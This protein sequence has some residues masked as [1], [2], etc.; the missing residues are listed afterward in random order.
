M[1][2]EKC[3]STPSYTLR[4]NVRHNALNKNPHCTKIMSPGSDPVKIMFQNDSQESAM[5]NSSSQG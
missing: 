1:S 4:S 3:T 5:P 2:N